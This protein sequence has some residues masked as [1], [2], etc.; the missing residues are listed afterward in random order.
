MK[1]LFYTT[2]KGE[3]DESHRKL[4]REIQGLPEGKKF[5]VEISE[6]KVIH[7]ISQ[8]AYFH[9]VCSIFAI[10]T[11]HT[12]QEIKDDFKKDR[13]FEIIVDKQGKEFKRLLPTSGLN[14]TE[15]ASLINN[16][17]QWGLDHWP[18]CVV[19]KKEDMDYIQWMEYE[20]AVKNEYNKTFSGW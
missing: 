20:T 19:S 13:F 1:K 2:V 16:L 4:G 18:K 10:H 11:G 15:Y 7:S 8:S 12:L 6:L 9:V 3:R 17:L 14:V 5:K